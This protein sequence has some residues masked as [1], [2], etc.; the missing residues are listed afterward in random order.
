MISLNL[1][2]T[3]VRRAELEKSIRDQVAACAPL[4]Q[5]YVDPMLVIFEAKLRDN[6]RRF[7]SALPRVR[8]HFAVKAN[9]DPRILAIFKE[10]GTCFEVASI[11]ELD[12]MH[13]L[14][15]EME[16]VF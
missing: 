11:A 5:S 6:A 13:D 4:T 7:M 8:P 14:G 3:Q 2:A 12:A 15:V 16:T 1:E 10:E 9:P